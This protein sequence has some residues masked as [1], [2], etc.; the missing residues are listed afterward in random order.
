MKHSHYTFGYLFV[1]FSKLLA[2]LTLGAA[3][4]SVIALWVNYGLKSSSLVYRQNHA[5]DLQCR[6]LKE[7]LV[8]A[9]DEVSRIAAV[10]DLDILE[11]PSAP[12]N[13]KEFVKLMEVLQ[14]TQDWEMGLK[15]RL[16]SSFNER[17]ELLRSKIKGVI[18]ATE[19]SRASSRSA[20]E[21]EISDQQPS[22]SSIASSVIASTKTV[23]EN[24][25]NRRIES[26]HGTLN[27][28]NT[29][30]NRL[31][32][33]AEKE[34]N[35]RLIREAIAALNSLVAWLPREQQSVV[36]EANVTPSQAQ[37][38]PPP[39]PMALARQNYQTLGYLITEINSEIQHG[40]HLDKLLFEATRT[41]EYQAQECSKAESDLKILRF[42]CAG[43]TG[44]LLVGGLIVA[45]LVLVFADFLQSFFDT[46]SN[47][48]A[49][50]EYFENGQK[51]K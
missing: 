11:I 14:A 45:F 2:L 27:Q 13:S 23:F 42:S 46:A 32:E 29:V 37:I 28:A 9:K 7:N 3:L 33:S 38:T 39:D 51:L 24:L 40:W 35:K 8:F 4:I 48:S 47:S 26:M 25:E 10:S 1:R 20:V 50:R 44:R 30:L 18:E 34:E 15:N 5:L 36:E 21:P 31:V 6:Q 16:T 41:A 19:A 22:P 49:I 12:K 17:M 43:D